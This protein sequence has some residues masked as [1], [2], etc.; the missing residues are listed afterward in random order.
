MKLLMLF[1]DHFEDTEAIATLD[2]LKRAGFEV[3]TASVMNRNEVCPKYVK[4]VLADAKIEDVNYKEFDGLVIPGGPG[5]FQIMPNLPIVEQ[6]IRYFADNNKLVASICAAPH[7]VG[8]LGYFNN[9]NFTVH[10]GFEQF[11]V[12]GNYLREKGVVKSDNF[13]TAKS[14]YYSIEFGLEIVKYFK[15]EAFSEEVKKGLQGEG[16]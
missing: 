2:V 16:R 9:R 8:K 14:M 5:S 15:G 6:L 13:I 1:V 12:G 3:I 11:C 7:L 10:P 4:A